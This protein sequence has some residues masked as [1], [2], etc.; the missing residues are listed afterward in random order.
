MKCQK[1]KGDLERQPSWGD[2]FSG[3]AAALIDEDP[4]DMESL[5][6][7]QGGLRLAPYIGYA[8]YISFSAGMFDLYSSMSNRFEHLDLRLPGSRLR[9]R[10]GRETTPSCTGT[11][12][13]FGSV[14][15]WGQLFNR[16]FSFPCAPT[17]R[18]ISAR[19]SIYLGVVRRNLRFAPPPPR[20]VA[21][22]RA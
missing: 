21:P 9:A 19:R 18:E 13:A 4:V 6:D 1:I 15:P 10:A 2:E 16:A 14:C 8:H 3:V 5:V 22:T 7:G 11:F 20:G 12:G 17:D